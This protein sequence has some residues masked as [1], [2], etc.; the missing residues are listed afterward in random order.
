MSPRAFGYLCPSQTVKGKGKRETGGWWRGGKLNSKDS[1]PPN[2]GKNDLVQA[3]NL[4]I[5]RLGIVP[6]GLQ[7]KRKESLHSQMLKES[8]GE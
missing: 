6:L 4:L 1:P 8:E 7:E 3:P 2:T 5:R